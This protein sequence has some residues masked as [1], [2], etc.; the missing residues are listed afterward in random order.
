MVVTG[1]RNYQGKHLKLK[2]NTK[3][4]YKLRCTKGIA[5]LSIEAFTN[6]ATDSVNFSILSVEIS[7]CQ[8]RLVFIFVVS[9]SVKFSVKS[10]CQRCSLCR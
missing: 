8:S 5:K 3:K 6:L 2:L 10:V 7:A 9:N 4:Q 1:R